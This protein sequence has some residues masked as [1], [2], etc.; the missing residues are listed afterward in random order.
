MLIDSSS[1]GVCF[2]GFASVGLRLERQE[3]VHVRE[4]GFFCGITRVRG[5][6]SI[7]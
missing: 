3:S 7:S 1:V 6:A 2:G 4:Q 5:E